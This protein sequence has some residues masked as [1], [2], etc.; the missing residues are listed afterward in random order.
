MEKKS[1][2][3]TNKKVSTY[4][5]DEISFSILSKL[6]VKS[7]KR[8]ECVQKSWSFLFENHH[9]IN[10]FLNRF[11]SYNDPSSLILRDVKNGRDIF[12]SFSGE[13]FE[14][15]V[16]L[17][18]HTLHETCYI[19]GFGSINGT[20]CFHGGN[21]QSKIILWKPATRTIELLPPSESESIQLFIPDE[22]K[23][24]VDVMHYVHGFGYDHVINDY[25]VIRFVVL[26]G[27]EKE[28]ISL[29][30]LEG[31][32]FDPLW[33]IY[34]LR[35][36]SWRKL[37]IDMPY[38]LQYN[39]G[40]QVYMDGVCHWLSEEDCEEDC[41]DVEN[42]DYKCLVSF[43]LSNEKFFVTP[44]PSYVDDCFDTKASWINL[45]VLNEY[46]TLISYHKKTTTFHISILSE[47]GTKE[48]WTKLLTVGP[49][50]CVRH[51][52][53]MGPKGEIFLERKDKELV[54]LDL[55]TQM[56]V[57]L[58]FKADSYSQQMITYKE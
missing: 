25:K 35:S 18:W 53:K 13:R 41:E 57:E 10:M 2:T 4:I 1:M 14:N 6:P 48:S 3:A 55:S 23:M 17:D 40:T 7:L 33:E 36:N 43:Y 56:I 58:G 12:Y 26:C 15:K 22:A 45:A 8:F 20:F 46:I 47:F 39:H 51:P 30:R 38:S 34:S 52:M 27:E 37:H 44:I 32:D 16:K 31:H 54:W 5:P 28:I 24:Y 21:M 19:D 42:Y 50:S 11:L 29:D 49:L 9:F